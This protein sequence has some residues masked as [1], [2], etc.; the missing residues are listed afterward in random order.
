MS[1]KLSCLSCGHA[2][3]LSDA[4]EDYSGEVR[5]WGCQAVMEVSL[6]EGKLRTMKPAG[7]GVGY[8]AAQAA[9]SAAAAEPQLPLPLDG[10]ARRGE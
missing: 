7:S 8:A 10:G 6:T 3:T 5:C 1:I 2:F 9:A 4:Y